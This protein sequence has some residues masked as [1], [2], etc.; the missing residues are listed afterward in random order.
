[1]QKPQISRVLEDKDKL[2]DAALEL[3]SVIS[4]KSPVAVQTT[5]MA[6]VH[7]RDH[8]VPDSLNYMVT[9]T[10]IKSTNPKY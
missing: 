9:N 10:I 3:A 5:K 4:S 2:I 6:L 8:S 1:M 7:S